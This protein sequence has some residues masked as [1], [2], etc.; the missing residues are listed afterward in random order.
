MYFHLL[1]AGKSLLEPEVFPLVYWIFHQ[2][3]APELQNY[4]LPV[5]LLRGI[6]SSGRKKVLPG[7]LIKNTVFIELILSNI[8]DFI[9]QILN[10]VKNYNSCSG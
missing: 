10:F 9:L 8:T 4:P 5:V 6:H 7:L 1:F 3:N 2:H